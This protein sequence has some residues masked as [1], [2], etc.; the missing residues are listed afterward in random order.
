VTLASSPDSSDLELE[1]LGP[2]TGRGLV[3]IASKRDG[4]DANTL[5][6]I[7]DPLPIELLDQLVAEARLQL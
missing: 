6:V 4:S 2:G 7:A 1:D 3:A 5:Q